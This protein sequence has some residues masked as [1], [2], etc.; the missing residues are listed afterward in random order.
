MEYIPLSAFIIR[1]SQLAIAASS[2]FTEEK[3]TFFLQLA[4]IILKG[5]LY[6]SFHLH[7]AEE[8]TRWSVKTTL[9]GLEPLLAASRSNISSNIESHR[10]ILQPFEQP[11]QRLSESPTTVPIDGLYL[12]NRARLLIVWSACGS[13]F[14]I[15]LL[16]F[17]SFSRFFLISRFREG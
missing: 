11:T 1:V 8:P 14:H 4:S 13:I 9:C 6:V 2:W 10:A 7:T 12:E 5:A 15:Q 16:F 17:R 3:C